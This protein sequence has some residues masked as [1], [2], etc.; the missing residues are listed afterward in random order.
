MSKDI[1]P[2]SAAGIATMRELLMIQSSKPYTDAEFC[3]VYL[4]TGAKD[5]QVKYTTWIR[6]RKNWES[7]G[8]YT[9][10]TEKMERLLVE[11]LNR[12]RAQQAAGARTAGGGAAFNEGG[13]DSTFATLC[14]A[15]KRAHGRTGPQRITVVLAHGG[16]GKTATVEHLKSGTTKRCEDVRGLGDGFMTGYCTPAWR[17]SYKACVQIMAGWFGRPGPWRNT[18]EAEA[19]LLDAA[20]A[21]GRMTLALDNCQFFALHTTHLF[22][23]LCDQTQLVPV[24]FADPTLWF[25]EFQKPTWRTAYQFHRRC[26]VLGPF[27]LTPGDIAPLLEPLGLNGE[28]A[29][30]ARI[31]ADNANLS[32][33]YDRVL[34]IVERHAEKQLP[35]TAD[36][37]RQAIEFCD[38]VHALNGTD[39]VAAFRAP[40]PTTKNRKR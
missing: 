18:M 31:V 14:K 16:F 10:K 34:E 11:A 40:A 29:A 20:R 7:G 9:G 5:Q 21:A 19:A 25:R 3:R 37:I 12:I 32:F 13:D 39:P 24:L 38:G 22:N 33:G 35:A 23:M 17:E 27:L 28:T 8:S 36:G 6:L 26:R 15:V 1:K 4:E 30:A 2:L